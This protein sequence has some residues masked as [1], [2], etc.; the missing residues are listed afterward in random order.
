MGDF[1][2]DAQGNVRYE[3][4]DNQPRNLAEAAASF[5]GD[6]DADLAALDAQPTSMGELQRAIAPPA[7]TDERIRK[8]EFLLGVGTEAVHEQT[9]GDAFRDGI[10][11]GRDAVLGPQPTDGGTPPPP[12]SPDDEDDDSDDD[13]DDGRFELILGLVIITLAAATAVRI[14]VGA[15]DMIVRWLA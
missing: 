10:T 7:Q 9:L 3:P 8:G 1:R 11:R 4:G 13:E 2:Y 15:W 14:I 12:D 6:W 5:D